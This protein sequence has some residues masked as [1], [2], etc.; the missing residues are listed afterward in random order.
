MQKIKNKLI[1][2]LSLKSLLL[3][4]LSA[5]ILSGIFT[6]FAFAYDQEEAIDTSTI[7]HELDA[8][9]T[10]S[11]HVFDSLFNKLGRSS[12]SD[13]GATEIQDSEI[14]IH[15]GSNNGSLLGNAR[16]N[17]I[18]KTLGKLYAIYIATGSG[19]TV[20]EITIRVNKCWAPNTKTIVQE[21]RA[22]IEISESK[23]K[24]VNRLFK[25]WIYAHSPASSQLIHPK[26]DVSLAY[27]F[28][29]TVPAK[30]ENTA[31]SEIH[32]ASPNN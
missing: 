3:I 22:L 24:V 10:E 11:L 2:A 14:R 27:C 12:D 17:L 20:N 29:S 26:Y 32:K 5:F 7:D 6:A 1:S 15:E 8:A 31:E 21:G 19:K 18:D 30:T 23:N 16:I 25:G 4:L 13:Q 9:N 28:N